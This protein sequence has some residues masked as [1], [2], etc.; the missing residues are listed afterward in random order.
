MMSQY[1]P[2][3]V[4]YPDFSEFT[5][6]SKSIR[7]IG[8]AKNL[9]PDIYRDIRMYTN[10]VDMHFDVSQQGEQIALH[11]HYF[12]EILCCFGGS[13]EYLLGTRRYRVRAGDIIVIPPNVSHRPLFS[14]YFEPPYRR[15]VLWANPEVHGFSLD[16]WLDMPPNG[17]YLLR[18]AG[19][20]W[21]VLEEYFRRGCLEAEAGGEKHE[22]FLLGLA[23]CINALLN[24]AR[25]EHDA[26]NISSEKRTLLDE[27]ITYVEK[28]LAE[29]I[30]LAGTA[31][32]FLVSESTIGK[33]F[34]SQMDVSF[35][36]YVVQ[37]RL[38]MAKKLIR[39]DIPLDRIYGRVGFGDYSSFYRAFKQE[40]NIS[41]NQ[42]RLMFSPILPGDE[43]EGQA[44]PR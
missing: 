1:L 26:P 9:N 5:I 19:T 24:R 8:E 34:R 11:S 32:H 33:V 21:E 16:D 3:F 44:L 13:V 2:G 4:C 10:Y 12:W 27:I 31:H 42:Y 35:Y 14:E 28:H 23:L 29:K 18:T 17:G 39:E 36:R 15:A 43:G 40:F 37:R 25:A 30:T 6:P 22:L 38:L 41:P 7:D 20:R